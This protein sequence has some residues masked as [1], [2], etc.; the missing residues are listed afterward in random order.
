MGTCGMCSTQGPLI[1]DRIGFCAE[2]VRHRFSRVWP[3]I[4]AV[5][6]NSR[7]R[8]GLPTQAP[9]TPGGLYCG[10]CMHECR[11]GEGDIGYCGVRRVQ[12]GRILGGRPHEGNLSFM[13]DPLP[14]NCVADYTCAGGTGCGYPRY[15]HKPGPEKGFNNLA[16]FY[17]ACGF[18]CLY[19]Q[20]YHFKRHTSSPGRTSSSE[21]AAAADKRTSCICYFG[22]DATPQILHAIKASRLARRRAAGGIMRIC[23]E[24]NGSVN[25]GYLDHLFQLSLVSGGCIKFDLKAWS[26]SVHYALCGVSNRRTLEN[27]RTLGGLSHQRR[28]PPLLTAS[29]LM[30][31]GYVDQ[32]EVRELA[33]FIASLDPEIPYSLLAFYPTFQ[34]VDL[35][36]TSR[37][38]AERCRRAALY[39]GLRNVHLGNEHLLR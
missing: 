38:Q 30:V 1:S 22:G 7:Q 11:M 26:E 2:C 8:Y 33:S 39:A 36:I 27:F 23:W 37:A 4:K 15:A 17:H 34:L 28:E 35:P 24:T 12:G 9:S 10:Q 6:D 13:H 3:R 32:E 16:V 19:C 31:P 20:N 29:T 25:P 18:N 21:L 14:T 5:H